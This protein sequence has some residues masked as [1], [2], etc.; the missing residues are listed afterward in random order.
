MRYRKVAVAHV[1]DT[2][3]YWRLLNNA[4]Y[5]LLLISH[6]LLNFEVA[7]RRIAIVTM[8]HGWITRSAFPLDVVVNG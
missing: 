4:L 7:G 1:S 5:W 3:P 8:F 6:R 2:P